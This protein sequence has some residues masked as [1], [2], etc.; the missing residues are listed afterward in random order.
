M[1]DHGGNDMTMRSSS[2]ADQYRAQVKSSMLWSA[3]ADALGFISELTGESGLRQR[4]Q[5]RPL[6]DTMAW[7]RR[8]GGQYGVRANLPAGTYSDD[9]QLRLAVARSISNRGFDVE[10]F[11][12]IELPVWPAYALGG[13]RASR[14]AAAG[15]AKSSATWHTNFYEGW[16]KSGGNGA[17][18]RIQ[19]HVWA[20][21]LDDTYVSTVIRD[22]VVT[23]GHPRALV[24]AV[25][26]AVSLAFALREGHT[27]S[28]QDWRSLLHATRRA[29]RFFYE[30]TNLAAIWVTSW[31]AAEQRSF[32][33]AW[34]ETVDECERLFSIASDFVSASRSHR[35][36]AH[37]SYREMLTG[38]GLTD[39]ATLGSG[40]ATVVAAVALSTVFGDRPAE[41]S[42]LAAHT[43]GSDTDTIATIAAA[44]IAATGDF[45]LTGSVQDVGYLES[46][47]NRLADVA[48]HVPTAAFTYP[49]TLR[50][51]PPQSQLEAVGHADERIALAGIGWL[52]D[53]GD[54]YDSRDVVWTWFRSTFGASFLVKHRRELRSLPRG[55]WPSER[56]ELEPGRAEKASSPAPRR[57]QMVDTLFDVDEVDRTASPRLARP[58]DEFISGLVAGVSSENGSDES[59]GRAIKEL[60]RR[61]TRDDVAVFLGLVGPFL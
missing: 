16:T 26:H 14:A 12:R 47:A 41:A 38:M 1:V 23:H 13:G 30:D 4:T 24:G 22:A 29:I 49:D 50:W 21:G 51:K 52:R 28:E 56:N 46:E 3:W 19:P 17:A 36:D 34:E 60:V 5:G 15:M 33:L 45:P 6:L 32:T 31:E 35:W 11:A 48:T 27:A 59:V 57:P 20:G 7:S 10:T 40:T 25:L 39:K 2:R 18:M 54:S 43:L 55:N 58:L 42:L 9:T 61:G 53:T 44:T 37:T 8:V